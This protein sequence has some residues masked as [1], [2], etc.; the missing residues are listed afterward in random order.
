M[1]F[2]KIKAV[3]KEEL[4][5]IKMRIKTQ[6]ETAYELQQDKV[7]TAYYKYESSF[8]PQLTW[9]DIVATNEKGHLLDNAWLFAT[10][11]PDQLQSHDLKKLQYASMPE[12]LAMRR[13]RFESIC[14]LL[15]ALKQYDAKGKWQ[16]INKGVFEDNG[17]LVLEQT[18]LFASW[19]IAHGRRQPRWQH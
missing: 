17:P 16:L 5:A 18:R 1:D 8:R 12:K 3:T 10:K 7:L 6:K 9:S 4:N 15:Q 13:T 19:M 11:T 14:R 2:Q